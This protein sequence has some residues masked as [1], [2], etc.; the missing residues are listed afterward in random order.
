[1]CLVMC[2]SVRRQVRIHKPPGLNV[3]M[4]KGVGV[5]VEVEAEV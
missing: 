4:K 5:E 1:M 2:R 3:E